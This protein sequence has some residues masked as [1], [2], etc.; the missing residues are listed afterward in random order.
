[1]N[2][3]KYLTLCLLMAGIFSPGAVYAE[4]VL[5]NVIVHFEP[6]DPGRKDVEISNQGDEPLY[7]EVE[8]HEVLSPGTDQEERSRILD[9]REAGLLVTPNKLILPPGATKVIRL[10]K[11]GNSSEERV[12][13]I[14][15]KPV[16]GGVEATQS[17]LKIMVGYEILAIVYPS[18]PDAKLKIE[19]EGKKLLVQNDGNTNV[20]LRQGFQCKSPDMPQEECTPLPSRRMYPGNSWEL[21]LPY[22]LPVKYYQ[23]V[24]TRNMVAEYP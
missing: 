13:R 12:Y 9:P 23:S 14:A 16:T 17:G 11:M 22:D 10:V 4:M 15:A 6:G 21:D 1:M 5:S 19:R 3:F 8:P 20:L 18:Q 2:K 7:V 24:G